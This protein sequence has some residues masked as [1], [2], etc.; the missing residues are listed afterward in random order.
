[1]QDFYSSLWDF[2]PIEKI[3]KNLTI[4]RH[5][6]SGRLMVRRISAQ[7]S[8]PVMNALTA[9]KHPNLMEVYSARM[10]DGICESLCEFINGS[11]IDFYVR[12]KPYE[13]AEARRIMCEICNGLT[14][15][16][17]HGLVH[18]DIKPENVMI[19]AEGIVKIIDYNISRL[20]KPGQ[21]R[22]TYVMG[23]AGYAS[24]E[25]FGFAQTDG[26]ADIYA[27]GVLLNYMLT[28]CL[29][30][31]R[32]HQGVFNT[33]I[34]KCIEVDENKRYATAEELKLVLLGKRRDRRK[35]L[36]PLPG[37]RGKNPFVKFMAFQGLMIYAALTLVIIFIGIPREIQNISTGVWK[38]IRVSIGILTLCADALLFW[39]AIPY[40]LFGD[41]FRLSEKINPDN[42]KNGQYVLKILG[43]ASILVGIVLVIIALN[44][45]VQ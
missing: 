20:Q 6:L 37:F 8:Y 16:H 27:C 38:N 22:D 35:Q 39:T 17:G 32:L 33:V 4:V 41:V 10:V 31:E 9:V 30:S 43:G 15:L 1:M 21:R 13:P 7:D 25:Q 44:L 29:P 42:P 12:T 40:I 3:N 2:T 45:S 14:A 11:T 24:P 26:R 5:K 36:R 23:T 34:E 28:G 19:T 18:R